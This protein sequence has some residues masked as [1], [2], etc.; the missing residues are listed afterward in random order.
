M[1]KSK[2]LVIFSVLLFNLVG[3]Q[4]ITAEAQS[5]SGTQSPIFFQKLSELFS[6]SL[7]AHENIFLPIVY[8]EDDLP[9]IEVKIEDNVYSLLIDLGSYAQISLDEEILEKINKKPYGIAKFEDF[10]GSRYKSEK[11]L[12]PE[13]RI[14]NTIFAEVIAKG[15]NKDFKKKIVLWES[16]DHSPSKLGGK[17]G[18]NL[19]KRKNIF[20]D[21]L[22]SRMAFVEKVD[23]LKS[24]NFPDNFLAIPFEIT[25]LGITLKIKTDIGEKKFIL[26]SGSTLSA[27]RAS[28]YRNLA[29]QKG[30]NG[31]NYF[32]SSQFIIGNRSFDEIR[33]HLLDIAAVE[34]VDGVLGMDFM[35]HHAFYIDFRK[36]TLH[37]K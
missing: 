33:L 9:L 18:R 4:K 21:F 26:D 27:I 16:P 23:S 13:I 14:G 32:T 5:F 31:L 36:K 30:E 3:F 28:Q 37:I 8:D 19:L 34:Q 24:L 2:L 1:N 17:V 35:R 22:N 25:S 15:E 7:P 20:L 29:C 12:I 10:Q 11:Y 6:S